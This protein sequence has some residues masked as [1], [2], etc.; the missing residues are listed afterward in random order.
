MNS[1]LIKGQDYTVDDN[2]MMVFT[3]DYLLRRGY[4]CESGCRNCPYGF[5]KQHRT[6]DSPRVV[7]LV[8][9]W[10]ETLIEAGVHVV[11]RTRYCVHPSSSVMHIT[12]LGGT[13][14]IDEKEF[15]KLNADLVILDQ[16]E[17]TREM[18][19]FCGERAHVT[20]ITS[21]A[22]VAPAVSL[23]A[24]KLQSQSL[25]DIANRWQEIS[26]YSQRCR[27]I[28]EMPGVIDWLTPPDNGSK[29]LIYCI[30]KKPY[31]TVS[32]DTFIGSILMHLGYGGL[33]PS[34]NEKYPIVDIDHL[35]PKETTLLFSSEPYPFDRERDQ[36]AQLG[37]PAALVDG[38]VFSWFGIRT[39]RFLEENKALKS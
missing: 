21:I 1:S 23:M 5:S 8:P 3:A 36:I 27:P 22:D 39:L 34:Y 10:T 14:M 29:Q 20:H 16:E 25:Q 17:N 35:D 7:S 4:C 33:I 19:T 24:Q 2:G 30:W 18:A 9:S 11:G 6:R 37:F 31:M 15:F 12:H 32:K 38:E 28:S 26:K 13:K